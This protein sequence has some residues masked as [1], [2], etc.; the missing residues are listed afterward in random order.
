MRSQIS[1]QPVDM[2]SS[3]RHSVKPWLASRLP[4]DAV[5]VDLASEGFPLAGGRI[6]I[7]GGAAEPTLVYKRREHLVSVTE[8]PQA[9]RKFPTATRRSSLDGYPLLFWSDGGR[10]FVAVSDLGP[11]ELSKFVTAFRAVA[12]KEQ[13]KTGEQ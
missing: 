12:A 9:A 7:I 2:P 8:L 11:L 1:G 4:V 13:G 3:D 5:V 6:D 10:G